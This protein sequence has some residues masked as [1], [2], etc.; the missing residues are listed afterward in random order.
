[1]KEGGKQ[2][3]RKKGEWKEERKKGRY[4]GCKEGSKRSRTGKT[5]HSLYRKRRTYV[6]Q[7]KDTEHIERHY[8][9]S[10]NICL[11][12]PLFIINPYISPS[13]K[14]SVSLNKCLQND[15]T[16]KVTLLSFSHPLLSVSHILFLLCYF[17]PTL[18]RTL[19]FYLPLFC[20]LLS[21]SIMK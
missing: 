6:F 21:L 20:S 12:I 13:C 11:L 15:Y 8:L 19:L 14:L 2:R 9:K 10:D 7:G 4:E 5:N 17:L 3:E 1:M 16:F 18:F